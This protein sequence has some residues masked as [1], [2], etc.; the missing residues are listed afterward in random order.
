[1]YNAPE[2]TKMQ[3]EE[4]RVELKR[5]FDELPGQIKSNIEYKINE[6]STSIQGA[7]QW[8]YELIQNALVDVR[9]NLSGA[10]GFQTNN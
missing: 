7:P 6:I 5:I 10:F 3:L 2:L 9:N 4:W 1:M 8:L